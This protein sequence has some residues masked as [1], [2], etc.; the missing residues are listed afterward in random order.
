MMKVSTYTKFKWKPKGKPQIIW[1]IDS[2]RRTIRLTLVIERS[3]Y[4]IIHMLLTMWIFMQ[5]IVTCFCSEFRL[6]IMTLVD[7]A[8]GKHRHVPYRD[9]RLTFLRQVTR[10]NYEFIF[11]CHPAPLLTLCSTLVIAG[12]FRGEFKDNNY[13]KCQP[14]YLV[15]SVHVL[16]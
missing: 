11:F 13:Y 15:C 5:H 8:N 3:D 12:F 1:W 6:V 4:G 10:F 7:I 14:I 9:S 2:C 16:L